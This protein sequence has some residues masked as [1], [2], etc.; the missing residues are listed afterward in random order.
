M[1][2][3]LILSID[4]SLSPE[5]LTGIHGNQ[6]F[7]FNGFTGRLETSKPGSRYNK[8]G[9]DWILSLVDR[10]RGIR[11]S[12]PVF[13]SRGQI[14]LTTVRINVGRLIG[15]SPGSLPISDAELQQAW[16]TLLALTAWMPA[17][18]F[19]RAEVK[20]LHTAM[21]FRYPADKAI[22]AHE[23]M[24]HPR[25]RKHPTK[26]HPSHRSLY[27]LGKDLVISLYDKRWE[28][29]SKRP[30]KPDS[31]L[32]YLDLPNLTRLEF[33]LKKGAI[34]RERNRDQPKVIVEPGKP[35]L[36]STPATRL[37]P[38]LI[39]AAMLLGMF[40]N[41][42]GEFPELPTR[43]IRR[44]CLPTFVAMLH[45]RGAVLSDGTAVI[46]YYAQ[47]AADRPVRRALSMSSIVDAGSPA[48]QWSNILGPAGWG[49]Y[50]MPI[51][52]TA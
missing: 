6:K 51:L 39:T 52:P 28:L 7:S 40:R 42:V 35:P 21:N 33:R 38:S 17:G 12:G 48:F 27:W 29:L 9:A 44:F 20:E 47:F 49:P 26:F 46:D 36:Q 24:R 50:A 23:C 43:E 41:L 25:V 22:A 31:E 13:F 2:D 10:E 45:K 3:T 4:E 32:P 18:W 16:A 15:L 14:L 8:K 1:I 37:Q 5:F 19:D 34:L 30:R 11:I